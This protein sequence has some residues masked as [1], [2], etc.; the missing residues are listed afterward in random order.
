MIN[1]ET[2]DPFFL[3][4]TESTEEAILNS[5]IH[6]LPS[7]GRDGNYRRALSE[8]TEFIPEDVFIKEEEERSHV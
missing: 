8:F 6:A 1:E 4:V 3:A 5:L 2:I 7:K